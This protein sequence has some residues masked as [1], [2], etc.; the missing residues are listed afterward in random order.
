[1][2]ALLQYYNIVTSVILDYEEYLYT[3]KITMQFFAHLTVNLTI[4]NVSSRYRL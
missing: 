1:M 4:N 3:T 2:L